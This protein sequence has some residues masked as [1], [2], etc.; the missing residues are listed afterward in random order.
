METGTVQNGLKL[1]SMIRLWISGEARS[2]CRRRRCGA[3][4]PRRPGSLRSARRNI[5]DDEAVAEIAGQA[6]RRA[7][8]VFSCASRRC[9]NV[10]R[11]QRLVAHDPVDGQSVA[12]L[13][14]SH[15]PSM[16]IEDVGHAGIGLEIAGGDEALAQRHHPACRAP[17]R[18]RSFAGTAGQP[19]R[20]T[21]ASYWATAC[22]VVC[23][24]AGD[25][26]GSDDFGI[27][28]VREAAS[29]PW[30]K[31]P[32][33]SARS[34]PAARNPA[35]RRGSPRQRRKA[36]QPL[37]RCRKKA[38]RSRL[39]PSPLVAIWFPILNL[40]PGRSALSTQATADK[41]APPQ[42]GAGRYGLRWAFL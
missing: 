42:R 6:R 15:Q 23:A 20:A 26:V 37:A 32:F 11:L 5:A 39:A 4:P 9:R 10:E 3:S 2:A 19:P 1:I 31:P 24:V 16:R 27:W 33:A 25:S 36:R 40:V 17:M 38:R 30:P 35:P 8:L 13:E 18:S 34:D 41:A 28:M 12:R 22:S 29:K 7:R 21:M 14:P